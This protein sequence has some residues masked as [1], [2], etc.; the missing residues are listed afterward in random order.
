MLQELVKAYR[1]HCLTE[2]V[3]TMDTTEINNVLTQ[4]YAND[5]VGNR[6]DI[7]EVLKNELLYRSQSIIREQKTANVSK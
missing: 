3:K 6:E 5:I 2:Y 7:L 4:I 1:N